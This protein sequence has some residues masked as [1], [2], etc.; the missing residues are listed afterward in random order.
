MTDWASYAGKVVDATWTLRR[1]A[2]QAL[3]TKHAD[4]SL[5][6]SGKGLPCMEWLSILHRALEAA[7]YFVE[8]E[9]RETSY[10]LY[11]AALKEIAE[12]EQRGEPRRVRAIGWKHKRASAHYELEQTRERARRERDEAEQLRIATGQAAEQQRGE[13]EG[14]NNLDDGQAQGPVRQARPR[15]L[16]VIADFTGAVVG[17]LLTLPLAFRREV[18]F[19]QVLKGIDTEY[20]FTAYPVAQWMDLVDLVFLLLGNVATALAVSTIVCSFQLH[21]APAWWSPIR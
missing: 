12:A 7:G 8:E 15:P 3:G 2:E 5:I 17:L 10:A 16:A 19:T 9:E 14:E 1:D 18:V 21:P 20:R 13:P 4:L 11:M 6:L